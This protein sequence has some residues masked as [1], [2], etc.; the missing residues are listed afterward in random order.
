MKLIFDTDLGGDIDDAIALYLALAAPDVEILG[1]S[2]V[3]IAGEWRRNI[4]Q[5]I[6]KAFGREDIPVYIGE[7]K[8]FIGA[9]AEPNMTPRKPEDEFGPLSENSS[10][11]VSFIIEAARTNPDAII[12]AIGPLTNLALALRRAPW[13]ARTHKAVIMGGDIASGRPEWN[14]QCDP[15]AARIVVD[16]GMRLHIVGLNVTNRCRFS[17]ADVEALLA[18]TGNAKRKLFSE[19]LQEFTQ[20]FDFLPTLHDPLVL[21]A[22]IDPQWLVNEPRRINVE[23]RGEFTRGTTIDYGLDPSSSIEVA[24][25]VRADEFVSYM[26]HFLLT[27]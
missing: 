8:P 10:D 16:S 7:E 11:A 20:R 22:L 4:I 18:S 5:R 17:T 14:I 12:V 3:Y 27:V 6:L 13:L 15:E 9:W 23:T 1:I 2:S 19:M 25:D 24:V 26:K 21:A